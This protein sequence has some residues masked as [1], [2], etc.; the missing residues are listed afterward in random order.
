MESIRG[1]NKI[2]M[3]ATD[4]LGVVVAALF[5]PKISINKLSVLEGLAFGVV[6]LWLILILLKLFIVLRRNHQSRKELNDDL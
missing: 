5:I 2:K 4:L 3:N 1:R 6:T